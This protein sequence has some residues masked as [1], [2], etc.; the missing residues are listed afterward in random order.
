M[1]RL[2]KYKIAQVRLQRLRDPENAPRSTRFASSKKRG[3]RERTR[4]TSSSTGN[5]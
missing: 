1:L 2:G 3:K 4:A 5:H